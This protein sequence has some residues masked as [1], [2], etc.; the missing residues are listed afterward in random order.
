MIVSYYRHNNKAF[1]ADSKYSLFVQWLKQ[2]MVQ[3]HSEK[4]HMATTS[5]DIQL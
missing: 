2:L 1:T 5:Y 4:K 3:F